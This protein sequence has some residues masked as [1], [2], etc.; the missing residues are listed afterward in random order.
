MTATVA[1]AHHN[2]DHCR[3]I[4]RYGRQMRRNGF[5]LAASPIHTAAFFQSPRLT[6]NH[7]NA[8]G[9]ITSRLT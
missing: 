5:T 4:A 8:T 3:R 6:Y 9:H 7:A 1:S 2:A